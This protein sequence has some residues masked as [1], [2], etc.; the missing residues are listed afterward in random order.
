MHSVENECLFIAMFDCVYVLLCLRI[1]L[2]LNTQYVSWMRVFVVYFSDS[3]GEA[4]L[5]YLVHVEHM[6]IVSINANNEFSQ[7]VPK[8][9]IAQLKKLEETFLM[10]SNYKALRFHMKA[11]TGPLVP[12][13]GM[14]FFNSRSCCVHEYV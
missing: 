1:L 3:V 12:Y 5:F 11:C 2:D 14:I 13:I 9:Q 10:D 8:K 4:K 7:K 6:S